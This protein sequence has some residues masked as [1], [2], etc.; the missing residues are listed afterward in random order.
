MSDSIESFSRWLDSFINFE[1]R[2]HSKE[3]CL[4]VVRRY[5]AFFSYPYTTYRCAHIAGSKGKG[6]VS[7]FLSALLTEAGQRTGVYRS[8]HVSDIRERIT[9]NG[10]FFSDEV[11]E[12]AYHAVRTGVETLKN[13]DPELK[14]TWFELLTLT[15][16]VLFAQE[17]VDWAVFETG[18]GGR[19]DATNVIEPELT[20]LTPI[21]LEHCACLGN[22]LTEIA[23]E[24]AGIIKKGI[25]VFCSTQAEEVRAVFQQ[26]AEIRGAPFFYVPEAVEQMN[27]VVTPEGLDLSVRFSSMHPLGKLFRRPLHTVL[28][29]FT[30]VQAY[31]AVLAACACK[32][33]F[34]DMPE[35]GIEQALS[36]V[37]L[38]AR[39]QVLQ[40]DPLIVLD[41]AHT[42]NSVRTCIET[43]GALTK[44]KPLLVFACARD[45]KSMDMA[46]HFVNRVSGIKL[47]IPGSFKKS[48]LPAV[49]RAFLDV[50]TQAGAD[51]HGSGDSIQSDSSATSCTAG[52][53][54]AAQRE[55][56]T[57][58]LSAD[59]DFNTVLYDAFCQSI[60]ERRPLLI[61][62]SCYLAGEAQRIYDAGAFRELKN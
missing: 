50:F 29:L 10:S 42:P 28:K 46:A 5:A 55:H 36:Q 15:A 34:P 17:Q 58:P 40:T 26:A 62:G 38:P 51:R 16:F 21:E 6:S 43:F 25:P 20:L 3:F 57:V 13:T 27:T 8:P 22:T 2:P 24:K 11:Y 30:P 33:A 9:E 54:K 48:D 49:F 47:T 56:R 39:F 7:G 19:L 41:G 1:K 45:K 14:P 61:T 60:R 35:A 37:L 31:N 18:M 23:G 4:D 52:M 12:K 53:V 59:A 32:Y 44:E